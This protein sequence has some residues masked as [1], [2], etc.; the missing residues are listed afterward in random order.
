MKTY[1][2]LIVMLLSIQVLFAQTC[3]VTISTP[4]PAQ[5]C[6]GTVVNLNA[7]GTVTQSNQMFNF[8]LGALPQGWSTTG[9]TNY[10]NNTCG[11]SLDGTNYFW[12]STAGNSVPQIT[13]AGFDICSGGTIEFDMRYAIQGGA[14]PCEGPDL[15]NEGVSI[16]YSLD[17]GVTWIEFVYFRPDGVQM[18][19]NPINNGAGVAN[20]NTPYTVWRPFVI[21]IPA[22]AISGNTMFRWIQNVSSGACCDNWGLDNIFINA[23]PC[24]NTNIR[25][26]T[27]ENGVPSINPTVT[28]NNSCYIASLYDDNN[29]YLCESTPI[30]FNV[31]D[32]QINGGPD[33]AVCEGSPATLT[34]T[35]GTG[36]SWDNGVVNG[37]AFVPSATQTYT[38]TGVDGNGCNASDQVV[39][40]VNPLVYSNFTYPEAAYCNSETNPLPV[41]TGTPGG[42][43]SITPATMNINSATGELDLASSTVSPFGDYTI[44]YMPPGPCGGPSTF[45]VRVYSLPT[46]TI[47]G[48]IE[49]CKDG[50]QPTITFTGANATSPYTFTYTVGSSGPLTVTTSTGNTATVNVPTNNEGSFTYTLVSVQEGGAK[51]CSNPQSGTAVITVNPLP[52]ATI[53]GNTT[54]CQNSTNPDVTIT[55]SNGTAPYEFTYT[56]DGG[57]PQTVT[58]NAAGT[59]VLSVP[60]G[61]VGTYVYNITKVVDASSTACET[62]LSASVSVVVKQLPTATIMGMTEVCQNGSQPQITFTGADGSAPYTFTYRIGNGTDQTVST[63]SGSSS[64]TVNAPT[65]TPGVYEYTLISVAEGSTQTCSQNQQGSVRI[66]VNELPTATIS[67][68]ID[69]CQN[70]PNP[71]VTFTGAGG[72]APYEF[73]FTYNGGPLQTLTSTGSSATLNVP[74]ATPG[75]HT[76]QLIRVKDASSTACVNNQSGTAVVTINALPTATISGTRSICQNA[77]LPTV[78]F[79]GAAGVSPYV[80]TYRINGGANQT[81]ATAPGSNTVQVNVPTSASGTFVYELVSVSDA[82][83]TQCNNPQSGTATVIVNPLPLATLSGTATLC[84]NDPSPVLIF[85]GSNG[86]APYIFNYKLNG[87][88][89]T[90]T[91]SSG[92]SVTITVPTTA[93]GNY[94]YELTGVTDASS[95]T[96]YNAQQGTARVI[97]N[98]LPPVDAGQDFSVCDQVAITLTA[99]GA[100]SYVWTPAITNGVPFTPVQ[101][102]KYIVEGTDGNGCKQIDSITVTVIPIPQ[103]DFTPTVGSS[104]APLISDVTNLSTGNLTNCVWTLSDGTVYTGCGSQ[105]FELTTPGCYD[106][107]LAVST[108]EGCASSRIIPDFFCVYENP[109]ADFTITP[110]TLL[111]VDPSA[112]TD[113]TSIGGTSFFWDFGDNSSST[114]FEPSHTFPYNVPGN[115]LV[116]LY[117]YNA[118]RC[119]DSTSRLVV[120]NDELVYYV[121]NAFTPDQDGRNEVFKPV[122]AAGADIYSYTMMIYDR[123]GEILFE[124]HNLDVGWDGY[125]MN[126]LMQDGLYLWKINIR[127]KHSDKK[128]ELVGHLTL[129]K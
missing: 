61:T 108:P 48:T 32:P 49:V 126:Q 63:T 96:C 59:A 40:T 114:A 80:F 112:T 30:C 128:L 38:V 47:A 118:D 90:I 1:L 71:V 27:G 98:E 44:T 99:T 18:V 65:T 2:L 103:V 123:W 79:T 110:S 60:T 64:T 93:A 95:T 42:V 101:T 52:T 9:G 23:G 78:T 7:V 13:T 77:Q 107:T 81:V 68:T 127:H 24:M 39:V 85:T 3:E 34:A 72:T 74:S 75:V 15:A 20:G 58:S 97:I 121:P 8:N 87:V 19:N 54:V 102:Q 51:S 22:A 53:S 73:V 94:V 124:T 86:T 50:N 115:Y 45:D 35:G 105:H 113:N 69:I 29:V 67:G 41:V 6:P 37:V 129:L 57:I 104:C 88:P 17:G 36:F 89:Q 119:M 12:A 31:F 14:A 83:S 26:S 56:I 111:S 70:D 21:P 25:W 117:V 55:G 116:T 46:A 11:P 28:A 82:S 125:Y 84:K 92:N 109:V 62:N 4:S 16:E 106:L 91:T 66:T 122:F 10:A 120:V 100:S 33:Q 43:F 76:Y 5:V